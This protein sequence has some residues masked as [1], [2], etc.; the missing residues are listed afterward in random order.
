[1]SKEIKV[2]EE[3]ISYAKILDLGMKAGLALLVVTFILYVSGIMTPHIPVE[4][5]PNYWGLSVKKYL[6]A[7]GLHSGW[8]CPA[9]P[10]M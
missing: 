1:M 5:L 10:A 2:T 7:T 4:E 3:Q 9:S 6:E 8:S